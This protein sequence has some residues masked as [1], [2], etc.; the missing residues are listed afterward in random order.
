MHLLFS[1]KFRGITCCLLT[2]GTSLRAQSPNSG[3]IAGTVLNRAANAPVRRA[4]VTLSTVDA[5]PQDANQFCWPQ[6][7][8]EPDSHCG[9]V[10]SASSRE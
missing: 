10:P 3:S 7:K 2:C 5:Q 4:I 9:S 1:R 6:A 8:I